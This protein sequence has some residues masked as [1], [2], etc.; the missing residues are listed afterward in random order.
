MQ[1]LGPTALGQRRSDNQ[2]P[3]PHRQKVFSTV[4]EVCSLLSLLSGRSP[5]REVISSPNILQQFSI[6]NCI[7]SETC[8]QGKEFKHYYSYSSPVTFHI[9]NLILATKCK[10]VEGS[11]QNGIKA[12]LP[13][14]SAL[15]SSLGTE[16]NL[17]Q[18]TTIIYD[19]GA[20]LT[21]YIPNSIF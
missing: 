3:R 9:H 1:A 19:F 21:F 15:E 5:K 4:P 7:R 14:D 8:A 13:P 16:L 18:Q 17:S 10:R 11:I 20:V 12:P 2:S 6:R